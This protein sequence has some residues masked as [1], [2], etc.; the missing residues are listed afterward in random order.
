MVPIASL[1]P[2]PP[3][4]V[5]VDKGNAL[6]HPRFALWHKPKTKYFRITR[7]LEGAQ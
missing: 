1:V 7:L 5:T 3:V 6:M 2:S 4:R